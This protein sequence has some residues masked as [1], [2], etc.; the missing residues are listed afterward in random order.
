MTKPFIT[1]ITP[2]Y[3]QAQ[4]VAETIRSVLSQDYESVEYRVVNDGSTDNTDNVIR[5][6][7]AGS[8]RYLSQDNRG[9]SRTLNEQWSNSNAKYLSYLSSDDLLDPSALSRAI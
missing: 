9:Q 3:N 6:V 4:F 2:T 1:M 5:G 7:L 8:F